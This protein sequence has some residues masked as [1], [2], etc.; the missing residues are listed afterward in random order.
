M[1]T[2]INRTTKEVRQSADPNVIDQAAWICPADLALVEHLPAWRWVIDGDLVRAPTSEEAAEQDEAR[3]AAAKSAKIAAIDA[4]VP[5]LLASGVRVNGESISC[6]ANAQQNL[7][8]LAVGR[9]TGR[10]QFPL[11]L[12]TTSGGEHVVEDQA[13]LDRLS[14]LVWTRV[15]SLLAQGRSLRLAVL[16]AETI[17]EV[18]EVE[19]LRT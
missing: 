13:E 1:P 4:R 9:L 15:H 19:D 10:T 6:S 7:L 17:A 2:A 12:S 14:D 16:A 5:A 8:A 3:L 18:D 11:G